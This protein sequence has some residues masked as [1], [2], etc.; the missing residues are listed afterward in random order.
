MSFPDLAV[1]KPDRKFIHSTLGLNY[2]TLYVGDMTAAL[3]RLKAGGVKL[4]ENLRSISAAAPN[5]S[6][7]RTPTAPSSS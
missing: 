5:W 7:F 4:L 6:P 2:L 3:R 1:A